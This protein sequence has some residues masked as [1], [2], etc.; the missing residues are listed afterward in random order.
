MDG[1]NA[2]K[3]IELTIKRE[4]IKIRSVKSE[5]K[6]D[7]VY[8]R[9]TSFTEETDKMIEKALEKAKKDSK[10]KIKGVIY[11]NRRA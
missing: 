6:D 8:I 4:E 10:N 7:V 5:L 3:P 2:Q 9:I 11:K 1:K